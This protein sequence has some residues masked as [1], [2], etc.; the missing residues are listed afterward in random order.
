MAVMKKLAIAL[1][2]TFLLG[3][4]AIAQAAPS[5]VTTTPAVANAS[6]NIGVIDL[7]A[8][9]QQ[10][11]DA[12]AAGEQL[13]KQFQPRQQKIV[14][15]Q[16]QLQKDQDQLRRNGSVMS[17]S[18]LQTLQTKIGTESRD[19]QQMQQNYMQDLRTAQSQA[20][21]KV[22]AQVDSIVQNVAKKN[23]FDLIIQK[24]AVAYSSSRVD[25]T[26]QVIAAMKDGE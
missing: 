23:N 3:S 16:N 26:D 21:Q 22:L 18:D 8:V 4:V 11:S 13:K 5:T 1:G 10:S 9:L 24:N 25:V 7:A 2:T 19:L 12:K 17:S 15:E 14:D 20:M 6:L